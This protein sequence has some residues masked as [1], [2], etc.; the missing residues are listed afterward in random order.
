MTKPS[1]DPFFHLLAW[2]LIMGITSLLL[3]HGL[4]TQVARLYALSQER[5]ADELGQEMRLLQ[6]SL[7]PREQVARYLNDL[8][9]TLPISTERTAVEEEHLRQSVTAALQ[10]L[11]KRLPMFQWYLV[12][13]S[14]D[15]EQVQ[16][17]ITHGWE[18]IWKF[19]LVID[20]PESWWNGGLRAFLHLYGSL[21]FHTS[22]TT[23]RFNQ[24]GDILSLFVPSFGF[25]ISDQDEYSRLLAM[26]K[27]PERYLSREEAEVFFSELR[28]RFIGARYDHSLY[29]RHTNRDTQLALFPGNLWWGVNHS[30]PATGLGQF[31]TIATSRGSQVFYWLPLF[32]QSFLSSTRW[33]DTSSHSAIE[34]QSLQFRNLRGGFFA[35]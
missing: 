9:E 13:F 3:Q 33:I 1:R 4:Q 2:T 6:A 5:L 25:W 22:P 18:R 27:H 15:R 30:M 14:P 8:F 28:C 17:G 16:M 21:V 26:G 31:D 34:L 11:L 35:F 12:G 10:P 23:V 7:S 32:P 29:A 19:P 24:F 20:L